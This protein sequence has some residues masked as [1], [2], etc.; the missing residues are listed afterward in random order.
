MDKLERSQIKMRKVR[1]NVCHLSV[2]QCFAGAM[3]DT[4]GRDILLPIVDALLGI[5]SHIYCTQERLACCHALHSGASCFQLSTT[6]CSVVVIAERRLRAPSLYEFVNTIL[7]LVH[8]LPYASSAL[9][10]IFYALYNRQLRDCY[11][12]AC[13]EMSRGLSQVRRVL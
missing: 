9:N 10:W 6:V 12:Q 11:G 1:E 4:Y 8:V 3:V 5:V 7:Q 13:R 2:V